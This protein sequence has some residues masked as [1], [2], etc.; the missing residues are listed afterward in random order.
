M[1]QIA[2]DKRLVLA[3]RASA[4]F[5]LVLVVLGYAFARRSGAWPPGHPWSGVTLI[6]LSAS[7]LLARTGNRSQNQ[8]LSILNWSGIFLMIAAAIS[9]SFAW[10]VALP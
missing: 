3:R 7:Q 5:V 8:L 4:L 1:A 10:F 6:A 9:W 2:Y